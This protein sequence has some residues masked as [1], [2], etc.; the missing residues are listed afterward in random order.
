[1]CGCWLAVGWL[2]A[3]TTRWW[4]HSFFI[5]SQTRPGLFSLCLETWEQ[6]WGSEVVQYHIH[7]VIPIGENHRISPDSGMEKQTP[8]LFFLN[9]F[10]DFRKSEEERERNIDLLLYPFV[11]LVCALTGDQTCNLGISGLRSNQLSNLARDRLH[12]LTWGATKS[13]RKGRGRGQGSEYRE[14]RRN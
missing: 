2:W 13:H 7:L 4:N 14:E 12:F 1:M 11:I 5:K 9:V 10:I 8:F 3:G 6:K